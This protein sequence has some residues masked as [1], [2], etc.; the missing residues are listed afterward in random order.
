MQALS[1]T[2]E[3]LPLAK[4]QAILIKVLNTCFDPPSV[5]CTAD[6][7]IRW[8]VVAS[9]E[10]DSKSLYYGSTRGH[11]IGFD[12][13]A[14][15]SPYLGI[16]RCYEVTFHQPGI[17]NYKCL[18]LRNMEGCIEVLPKEEVSI[19]RE[20]IAK[21][22]VTTSVC[23]VGA[24]TDIEKMWPEESAALSN[25]DE[26]I[27]KVIDNYMAKAKWELP[28]QLAIELD[29]IE[30]EIPFFEENK[31]TEGKKKR[32]RKRKHNRSKGIFTKLWKKQPSILRDLIQIVFGQMWSK[33]KGENA[34]ATS[35]LDVIH[36]CMSYIP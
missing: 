32:K 14:I 6:T 7:T 3:G 22:K 29:K 34:V 27:K 21:T 17:Y 12:Q 36:E 8:L 35:R 30:K 10:N 33:Y 26:S 1:E 4:S 16:D 18:I 19:S 28:K 15:E 9:K 2:N 20:E 13:I 31:Q 23:S 11:V 5:T 24:S 25:K